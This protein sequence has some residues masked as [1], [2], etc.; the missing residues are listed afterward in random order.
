[1]K[2]Q[3]CTAVLMQKGTWGHSRLQEAPPASWPLAAGMASPTVTYYCYHH[4]LTT[5]V[6]TLNP[7][8]GRGSGCVKPGYVAARAQAQLILLPT[9]STPLPV[10]GVLVVPE[11]GS[12]S[13]G[14]HNHIWHLAAG[15]EGVG[16]GE[17]KGKAL[18]SLLSQQSQAFKTKQDKEPGN[19]GQ[20]Q[21]KRLLIQKKVIQ[22]VMVFLW[23]YRFILRNSIEREEK[24]VSEGISRASQRKS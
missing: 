24:N 22:L 20:H 21:M 12:P 23:H 8:P 18:P 5:I 13:L 14:Q 10:I 2:G 9:T 6:C 3:L 7:E 19:C 11:Q 1:M 4:P 17:S 15:E 16:R